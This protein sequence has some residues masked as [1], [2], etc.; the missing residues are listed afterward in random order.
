MN[1]LTLNMLGVHS[2]KTISCTVL[3]FSSHSTVFDRSLKRR[4]RSFT[5]NMKGSDDYDYLR[6]EVA[7]RLVDRLDDITRTFPLALDMGCH[8][9]HIKNSIR[10]RNLE[11]ESKPIGGIKYLVE[12]DIAELKTTANV[13]SA[14]DIADHIFTSR[15]IGDDEYLPFR[16]HSFDLVLSAMALHWV[17]DI[18]ST[19]KQIKSILKPDGVFL[20]SML[21]GNTLPE[22]RH[23]FYLAEQ[24]RRGGFSPH[25]SPYVLPS[26][27]AGLMQQAGFSMPM[28]DMDTITIGYP[29]VFSLMEHI[30]CMGEGNAS[31]NRHFHVGRDTFLA[32][33]AIYQELYGLDDG[34]VTA[35]FQVINIIGWSPH[36]SQPQPK[37]RGSQ[38]M[39]FKDLKDLA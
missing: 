4:Q 5:L 27:M 9:G 24:D 10:E 12:L 37:K 23:S 14:K 25:A 32:M 18:P 8:R 30:R 13:N 35:T 3:S 36:E 38:Q 1:K 29:D 11:D 19:L 17:N 20:A 26:D 15:V 33:A 39:S 34:S 22:L 31:F 2:K 16:V 7:S 21:G 28:I 6:K